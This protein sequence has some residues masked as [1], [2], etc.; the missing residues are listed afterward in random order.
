MTNQPAWDDD[1]RPAPDPLLQ[2][3]ARVAIPARPDW[4]AGTV[5]KVLTERRGDATIRRV[6]I[7]FTHGTRTLVI[8]PALLAAPADEPTRT[9]G[10]IQTLGGSTLDD[11][12]RGV[13]ESA[14]SVLGTPL[15]KLMAVVALYRW[16]D[17]PKSLELWA[18]AQTGVADPL[19]HWSRDELEAAFARFGNERDSL[20]RTA[21]AL[22]RRAEGPEAVPLLVASLAEPVR[23]AVRTAL[24][25]VI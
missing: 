3:G 9:A 17:S 7:Q 1:E 2:V 14:T 13:P 22:L 18:R 16:D 21:G 20:L 15:E 8:P 19:T 5:R 4:G 11:R 10:W 12:L 23:E 25:R 24:R 6:T